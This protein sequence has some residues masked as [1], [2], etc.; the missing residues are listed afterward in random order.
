[1]S[2]TRDISPCF[3][4]CP[5]H[6]AIVSR[7]TQYRFGNIVTRSYCSYP[8]SNN[9]TDVDSATDI[10][11]F[12]PLVP[13]SRLFYRSRRLNTMKLLV[14]CVFKSIRPIAPSFPSFFKHLDNLR[15]CLLRS[16]PIFYVGK[17]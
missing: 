1:M 10:V 14:R 9:F 2:A 12:F 8:G 4:I 3:S 5:A 6:R 16:M 17:S 7:E 15:N 13:F 11:S